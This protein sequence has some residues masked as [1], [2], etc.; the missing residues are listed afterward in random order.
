[1]KDNEVIHR[2]ILLMNENRSWGGCHSNKRTIEK[3][4]KLLESNYSF[5][6]VGEKGE[7]K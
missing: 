7:G 1:M 6:S 5:E 2:M 4:R 3:I